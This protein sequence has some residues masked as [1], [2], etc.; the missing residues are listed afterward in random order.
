MRWSASRLPLLTSCAYSG[1]DDVTSPDLPPGEAAER[2]TARHAAF[3][4]WLRGDDHDGRGCDWGAPV[5][6]VRERFLSDARERWPGLSESETV[7]VVDVETGHVRTSP[8]RRSHDDPDARPSELRVIGDAFGAGAGVVVDWKT[9]R[10]RDYGAQLDALAYAYGARTGALAYV[11][12]Y[13]SIWHV[14]ERTYDEIDHAET[15]RRLR[16]LLADPAPPAVA[17]PHCRDKFCPLV[18]Q[19]PATR[20]ALDAVGVPSVTLSPETDAEARDLYLAREIAREWYVRA[21]DALRRYVDAHG[22]VPLADGSRYGVTVTRRET[23]TLTPEAAA[24]LPP[25]ALRAT[26]SKSA[27]NAALGKAAGAEALARLAEAGCITVTESRRYERRALTAR[28]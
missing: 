1:R 17:G 14:T 26:T 18:G 28:A 9:G 2:G 20:P 4:V 11:D 5:V 13:G 25:E 15:L 19:C 23:I 27:I 10:P 6:A 24:T 22:D 7:R 8:H 16:A 21:D 12:D 3:D